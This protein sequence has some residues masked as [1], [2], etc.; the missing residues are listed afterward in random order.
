M[1]QTTQSESPRDNLP[2]PS[3]GTIRDLLKTERVKQAFG[4]VLQAKAPQFIA[5]LANMVYA[6]KNLR[7]CDPYTVISAALK[8][9]VLDLPIEPS[10]GFA[11]IIPYKGQAQFQ[12]QWKGYVQLAH[13]S[14]QYANIHVTEVYEGMVK[15]RD[16]FTGT[17]KK[18]EKTG[19][20]LIGFYAYFKMVNGF[21]KE[22]FMTIEEVRAHGK[23]YS[24]TFDNKNSAW[25][26]DLNAMGRKTV[27]KRLL[28]RWGVLSVDMSRAVQAEVPPDEE[29]ATV[30]AENENSNGDGQ[31]AAEAV[32]EQE[33]PAPVAD[34][35]EHPAGE[36]G[37]YAPDPDAI[38]TALKA[39]RER[40]SAA[41]YGEQEGPR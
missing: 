38:D 32:V 37:D 27:L 14:S 31:V 28:T 35:G 2:A 18:G 4:D 11:A 34:D 1:T 21:E 10:L 15:G 17:I 26:T 16:P 36:T 33:S 9:A 23:R 13:R 5:S 41:L 24:K 12:M 40:D 30:H 20:L 8:A 19:D 3:P 25:Q 6:S 39:K 22:E 7:E 29:A